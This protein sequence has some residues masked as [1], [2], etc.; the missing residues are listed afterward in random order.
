MQSASY[1]LYRIF[2]AIGRTGNL[3]RA[4]QLLYVTQP[5]V[6]QALKA[7]ERQLNVT[8]CERSKRGV[9]LT[10]EGAALYAELDQAI[11][12]IQAAER[13]LDRLAN[14]ESGI[15]SIS[16]ADTVCN[17]YLLPHIRAFMDAHPKLRLSI[18]NRTSQETLALVQSQQ[19]ELGFV[20]LP[21]TDP[22][23]LASD[24]LP[25]TDVLVAGL[26]FRHLA[27]QP[28]AL[29][30]CLDFPFVL[31]EKKSA[32]RLSLDASLKAQNI[33]LQ[34][35]LELGSI[36]L[37]LSFVRGGFGL[38]FV[39]YELCGALLDGETL[40]T[41][42]LKKALPLRRLTLIQ[43]RDMPLSIASQAFK[44]HILAKQS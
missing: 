43:C 1:E 23:V 28:C 44:Q 10:V 22:A 11:A 2:W 4:A 9:R 31:L 24:C 38:T 32:S 15:I 37:I 26:P 27:D 6:S 40:F 41:V 19:V 13:K 33:V 18:T 36:D 16:A 12:H 5:S 35:I 8:L 29:E 39:P 21:V 3:T 14:L 17:Y 34:P 42:P 20:N 30:E 7:L 25:L